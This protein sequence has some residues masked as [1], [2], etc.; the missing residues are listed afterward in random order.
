MTQNTIQNELSTTIKLL[1]D[2]LGK[3]II[4][5][6]GDAVFDQVEQLRALS[7][8]WRGGDESA[9]QQIRELIPKLTD[10][11]KMAGANL[12]AFTTYFQLINLAEEQQ[13][14][15][16]LRERKR[17][18]ESDEKPMDESILAAFQ[19]LSREGITAEQ[20]QELLNQMIV[21][22][23]FTAH[24]TESKRRTI[25]QILRKIS[26][27]LAQLRADDLLESER[28]TI[29]DSIRGYIVLLWQS[30]ETRD[31]RPTVMDE[32]RNTG[33]Y[34][35]ENTLFDLIP[36]VY[37]EIEEA[38]ATVYPD[39]E[40]KVPSFLKYGSWI[41]GDR[42]G[43]PYVTNDITESALRSQKDLVL[44]RYEKLVFELYE[45]LSPALT[46]V[47]FT[48]AFKTSLE[49]DLKSI[50]EDEHEGL[51]RFH[52]E[53]YRQKLILMYRRLEATR[54]LNR[55]LWHEQSSAGQEVIER[56]YQSADEFAADLLSL[57]HI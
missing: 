25:R 41:G 34:F 23:V 9:N 27:H 43:N 49:A 47:E 44:E 28:Q 40:I 4:E 48:E 1:G 35:F 16:I 50:P 3:T 2:L 12:K 6:E 57:I 7:K 31:R 38:I 42:D 52:M 53:P 5:Q 54:T 21:A 32:V 51:D 20:V 13:R 55:S 46:R 17:Q 22:P 11:M 33:L 45:Q 30:D 37:H 26:D 19:T 15:S 10:D 24:P 36:E 14:V 18:A 39:S 56:A 29:I 8:A